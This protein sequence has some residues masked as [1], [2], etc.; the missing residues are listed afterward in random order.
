[1][2]KETLSMYL[3]LLVLFLLFLVASTDDAKIAQQEETLCAE[4][5]NLFKTSHGEY[6]W[7]EQV[8]N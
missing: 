4:M 8:C 1:M 7:P 5:V 6:G 2:K 3:M